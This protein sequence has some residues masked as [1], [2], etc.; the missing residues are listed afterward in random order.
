MKYFIAII[1]ICLIYEN[2]L[3]Q[4]IK[5][6]ENT[7]LNT[8]G[9]YFAEFYDNVFRGHFENVTFKSDDLFFYSI[10]NQYLR[11]YGGQCSK[12][13]PKNKVMIMDLE[14]AMENVTTNGYGI[15]SRTCI[16]WRTVP[17]GLYA[18]PDLYNTLIIMESIQKKNALQKGLNFISDPNYMG[19]S[20]DF[21]HKAKGLQ[22]D[23]LEIFQLNSCSSNSIARFDE[24][25]KLFALNKTGIRSK[26]ASK[27]TQ[28]KRLGGPT[29][30]QNFKKLI[31]DLVTKQS[32]T[33]AF[34]RCMLEEKIHKEDQKP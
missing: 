9:L 33:W 20:I 13:L 34:N 7:T 16:K 30:L 4:N 6:I 8:D 26:E 1:I 10:F 3:A 11:A 32:E 25:L 18:K 21:I 5:V 31:N 12:H 24:N 27:Y 22:K 15:E 17:S 19:N 23:L 14:C 2:S 28:A 29:G